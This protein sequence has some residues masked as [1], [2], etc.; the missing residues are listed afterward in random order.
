ML[1][2]RMIVRI[3]FDNGAALRELG[4]AHF[5]ST[6]NG[7]TEAQIHRIKRSHRGNDGIYSGGEHSAAQRL[8]TT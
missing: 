4:A 7:L 1:L 8:F 6:L 3:T 5:D 2:I